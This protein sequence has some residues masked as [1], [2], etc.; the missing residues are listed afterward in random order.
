[1]LP[2]LPGQ[3]R[4]LASVELRF[5]EKISSF[6][7]KFLRVLPDSII[8]GI[9]VR[10]SV[11]CGLELIKSMP[12]AN[13]DLFSE[14]AAGEVYTKYRVISRLMKVSIQHSGTETTAVSRA[15]KTP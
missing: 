1:M 7:N 10:P 12:S 15:P 2:A 6:G 9:C 14:K 8:G 3:M 4:C 11:A 13:V 5:R